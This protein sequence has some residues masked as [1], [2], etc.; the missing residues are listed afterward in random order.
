MLLS[1]IKQEPELVE[2][3]VDPA[4][5][6]PYLMDP[7][8]VFQPPPP[9]TPPR[10]V[11]QIIHQQP[12]GLR[13]ISPFLFVPGPLDVRIPAYNVSYN[14]RMTHKDFNLA[15]ILPSQAIALI[16]VALDA[17][18]AFLNGQ[19]D[20]SAAHFAYANGEIFGK[21]GSKYL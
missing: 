21:T 14:P 18:N 19:D 6:F 8:K 1:H 9:S 2:V 4:A 17:R 11:P 5:A 15:Y 7:N 16:L 20:L 10:V 13:P 3:D 12:A